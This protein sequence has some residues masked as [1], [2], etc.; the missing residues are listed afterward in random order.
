MWLPRRDPQADATGMPPV[1]HANLPA[2]TIVLLVAGVTWRLVRYFL[3]FPIWGDEASVCLNFIDHN[4]LDMMSRLTHCQ[5]VPILYLWTELTA[6]HWLGDSELAMRLV[7]LIAGLVSLILFWK[8]CRQLLSPLACTLAVGILAVS[9]FP[10]RHSC[11]VKPYAFDLCFSLLLLVLA[12]SWLRQPERLRYL[13]LLAVLAPVAV[14]ASYTAAFV[15]GGVSLVLLPGVWRRWDRKA[16]GWYV[17]FN[18]LLV[19]GFTAHFLL[20]GRSQIGPMGG[21]DQIMYHQYWAPSFPPARAIAWPLWLLD[22]HTGDLFAY[23]VGGGNGGSTL[24]TL[25]CLF[26]VVA[27]WRQKRWE[28]LGLCLIPFALNFLA[29]CMDRYPYGGVTRLCQHLAP[30]ICMLAGAGGALVLERLARTPERQRRWT[31]AAGGVLVA[32]AIVGITRDVVHPYKT[33][34]EA[35][36]RR[37]A[38]KLMADADPRAEIVIMNDAMDMKAGLAWYLLRHRERLLWQVNVDWDSLAAHTDEIWC[39]HHSEEGRDHPDETSCRPLAGGPWRLLGRS[40]DISQPDYAVDPIDH[41]DIF[42]WR[43]APPLDSDSRTPIPVSRR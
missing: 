16:I 5:I 23:P 19:S 8:L 18:L 15:A 31:W 17:L 4:Y 1:W 41:W 20:V 32:I 26:G 10:V 24:T 42:R 28:V 6:Y 13:V 25:L 2:W 38:S 34:D 11:E 33:S 12:A 7:S 9:Y 29:A 40:T 30:A 27:F 36:S 14:A 3:R 35:W 21:E 37:V 43:K 22:I 39:V